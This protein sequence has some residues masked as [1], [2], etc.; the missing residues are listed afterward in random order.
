MR[1]E[2]ARGRKEREVRKEGEE[3]GREGERRRERGKGG[4][5]GEVRKERKGRGRREGFKDVC[6]TAV[7]CLVFQTARSRV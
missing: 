4:R 3:G 7:A 6:L 2:L 1:E 5:G